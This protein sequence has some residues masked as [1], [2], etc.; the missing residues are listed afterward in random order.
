MQRGGFLQS[1]EVITGRVT[2]GAAQ[3]ISFSTAY[4][5][6]R[7]NNVTVYL[8]AYEGVQPS[9]CIFFTLNTK[10]KFDNYD[11]IWPFISGSKKAN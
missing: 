3:S 9:T 5:V 2:N 10:Q 4:F 11:H 8:I 1:G 6:R 7:N